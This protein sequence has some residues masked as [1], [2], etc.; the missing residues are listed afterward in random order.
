GVPFHSGAR[1]VPG[2]R[3]E[4]VAHLA[5]VSVDYYTRLERGKTN[6][7]SMEVLDAIAEA[8]QLDDA[9]REHLLHLVQAIRPKRRPATKRAQYLV[10]PA[11]QKVLDSITAPAYIQNGRM[12]LLYP[13]PLGR[14]IY[15][16]MLE[17]TTG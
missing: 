3:R 8:L 12:D 9:E 17:E 10:R 11:I 13:N 2:L 15:S 14:A 5:G 4:E 1:R 6:G 16:Q 7:A